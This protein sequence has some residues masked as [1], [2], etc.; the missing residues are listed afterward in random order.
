MKHKLDR[1]INNT[2][3][4]KEWWAMVYSFCAAFMA[5]VFAAILVGNLFGFTPLRAW[6]WMLIK[7]TFLIIT[8]S[9]AFSNIGNFLDILL[10]RS[11]DVADYSIKDDM[12]LKLFVAFAVVGFLTAIYAI[13]RL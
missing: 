12:W 4:N 3:K 2:I 5:F 11:K 6:Q 8:I 7:I 1:F 13:S 10:S 9:M